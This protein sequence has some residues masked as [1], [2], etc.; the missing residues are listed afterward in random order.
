[1][2]REEAQTFS[3]RC[4]LHRQPLQ[5]TRFFTAIGLGTGWTLEMVNYPRSFRSNRQRQN[6][7]GLWVTTQKPY[8]F[9]SQSVDQGKRPVSIQNAVLLPEERVLG[10]Q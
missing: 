4:A 1:M 5:P 8:F 9:L 10:L 6:S 2:E 3:S 7:S